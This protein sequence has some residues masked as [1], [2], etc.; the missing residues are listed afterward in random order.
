MSKKKH[1]NIKNK[2]S[3][4]HVHILNLMFIIQYVCIVY[5]LHFIMRYWNILL[6]NILYHYNILFYTILVLYYYYIS[7]ILYCTI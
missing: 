4:F 1:L 6:F 5:C 3:I 2:Y 7:I